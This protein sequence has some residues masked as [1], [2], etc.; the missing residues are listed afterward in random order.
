MILLHL[1][2]GEVTAA[3]AIVLATGF[4]QGLPGGKMISGLVRNHSFRCASCGFPIPSNHLEWW[5]GIYLSGTLGE[6]E[7]GPSAPNL[8]GARMA[9]N[10]ILSSVRK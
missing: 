7:T 1:N 6:L 10:K 2:S 3:N 9:A 5:D 8:I 4:E